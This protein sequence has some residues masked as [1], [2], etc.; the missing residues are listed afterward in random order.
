VNYLLVEALERYHHFYGDDF[1]VEYPTN[2]G[3]MKTL[4]EISQ[5]ICWRLT[6]LFVNEESQPPPYLGAREKELGQRFWDSAVLFNEYFDA[7]SGRGLGA[8]LQTGWTSLVSQ[9]FENVA[10]ARR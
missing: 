1:K 8:C 3:V 4:L 5:D 6:R 7:E 10:A 2:S 9:C